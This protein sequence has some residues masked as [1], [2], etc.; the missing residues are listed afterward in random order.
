ML[1]MHGERL[2]FHLPTLGPTRVRVRKDG[3][4]T[5]F[6]RET[7]C[8]IGSH[9]LYHTYAATQLLATFAWD[10]QTSDS[11]YRIP[12]Q[13][14]ASIVDTI[15]VSW[16]PST[17]SNWGVCC[18]LIVR[19]S[20]FTNTKRFRITHES[21]LWTVLK[22]CKLQFTGHGTFSGEEEKQYIYAIYSALDG[23]FYSV[24]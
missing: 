10:L 8:E 14:L 11:S 13:L 2:H 19:A 17:T 7:L 5:I 16:P 18:R 21:F 15:G 3:Q 24:R 23:Q 12:V 4:G 20:S 6:G 1:R 22:W 9:V